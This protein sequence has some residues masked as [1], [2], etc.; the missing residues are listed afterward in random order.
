MFLNEINWVK[1]FTAVTPD[2][3]NDIWTLFEN[4]IFEAIY[5]FSPICS[6]RENVKHKYPHYIRRAHV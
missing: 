2:D 3:V 1:I 6:L 5:L 4:L